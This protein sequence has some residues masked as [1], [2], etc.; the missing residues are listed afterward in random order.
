V[1]VRLGTQATPELVES[2]Q[3][4]AVIAAT[5]AKALVPP[6]PGVDSARVITA[7]EAYRRA[8]AGENLGERIAVLGGGDVGCE[9]AVYLAQELGKQVSLVEMTGVLA[10]TS[11]TIPRVAI[12]KEMEKC[13]D[14]HLNARC[15]AITDSGLIYTDAW[16]EHTLE[17]DTV[18]LAAGMVPLTAEAEQFR[19]IGEEFFAVGDCVTPGSVRTAVRTGYD[20]GIQL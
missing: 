9:T 15:T 1:E 14:F 12:T 18:V 10:Q 2:L 17:A 3:P 13:V 6:I 4:D 20:S 11:C 19:T 5:G 7:E 16:G 8:L